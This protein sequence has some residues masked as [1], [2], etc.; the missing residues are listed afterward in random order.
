[1]APDEPP[2]APLALSPVELPLLGP[3]EE[4]PQPVEAIEESAKESAASHPPK[5]TSFFCI[6]KVTPGRPAYIVARR[7]DSGARRSMPA[8]R[9]G[10]QDIA[11]DRRPYRRNVGRGLGDVHF[12]AISNEERSRGEQSRAVAI[13]ARVEKC[14][15]IAFCGIV[16][17]C[18]HRP[19]LD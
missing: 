16:R 5:R 10:G 8:A 6:I 12:A 2:D 18:S 7:H 19:R 9:Q 4:K 1:L 15:A 17:R 11:R 13:C 14:F 3:S